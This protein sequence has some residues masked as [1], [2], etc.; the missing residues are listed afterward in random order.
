MNVVL[1]DCKSSGAKL[2]F[3]HVFSDFSKLGVKDQTKVEVLHNWIKLGN[4]V[5]V[6]DERRQL[7][8]EGKVVFF[9]G[10][11]IGVAQEMDNIVGLAEDLHE[12]PEVY[13]LL[14]GGGSEV[15]RL[16]SVIKAKELGNIMIHRPVSQQR[17]FGM[18][19][20]FDIG[21]ISLSRKLK[22]HN[23]PG[24]MLGYMHFSKP[25]LACINPGN[26]LKNILE[27][28][29]SG[30]VCYSGE[31]EQLS[32]CALRLARDAKLRWQ[33]GRNGRAV[34]EERFSVGR[35]ASQIL[36]CVQGYQEHTDVVRPETYN[37][38]SLHSF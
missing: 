36:S 3:F 24:K 2:S 38:K 18:L 27:E 30:L 31:R 34:L 14:V 32:A 26:G 9:Y 28:S 5:E 1:G 17:Y 22:T 33:M 4:N 16:K 10:G 37:H 21:L 8:L 7:G 35:V 12:H 29:E 15:Q 23:L 25:I 19:S 6:G 13:F 11:N 20:Q